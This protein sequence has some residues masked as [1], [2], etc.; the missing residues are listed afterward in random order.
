ML[1]GAEVKSVRKGSVSLKG[2]FATVS[3]GELWLIN[4]HIGPYGPAGNKPGYEPTRSRKLLV[5][6]KELATIIGTVRQKGLTLLPLSVY[7]TKSRIK[8]EL[9]VARG[10]K[11]YEKRDLLKK[12]SIDREISF[13]LRQKR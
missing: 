13:Q 8:V 7:T 12:R 9:G 4:A 11:Q 6:K 5:K 2:A 3:N 1:S 10:K